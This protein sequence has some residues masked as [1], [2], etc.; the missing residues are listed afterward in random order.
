M[1][2]ESALFTLSSYHRFLENW[3][4]A[5]WALD[6]RATEQIHKNHQNNQ[7][8]QN[9]QNHS[10]LNFDCQKISEQP[11]KCTDSPETVRTSRSNPWPSECLP[12]LIPGGGPKRFYDSFNF[13]FYIFGQCISCAAYTHLA[14]DLTC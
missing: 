3:A 9:H 10:Q 1:N 4:P 8:N 6:R 12:G 7:N 2:A 11:R 14:T 5:I 13:V